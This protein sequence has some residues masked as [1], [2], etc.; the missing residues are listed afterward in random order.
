MSEPTRPLNPGAEQAATASPLAIGT[1]L[2]EDYRVTALLSDTPAMRVYRVALL[3]PLH[4]CPKCGAT[5]QED[6]QFCEECGAQVEQQTALLQETPAADP[7]GAALLADLHIDAPQDAAALPTV[8]EVFVGEDYRY[9]VLPDTSNTLMRFDALLSEAGTALDETDAMLIGATMAR[10][11]ALLHRNGLALGRLTLA[12]LALTANRDVVL[13]DGSAIRRS[14]GQ[15]DQ[16]DDVTQLALVLEKLAGISRQTRRLDQDDQPL[17][18]EN[19]LAT[20]ISDVRNGSLQDPAVLA[21]ALETMLQQQATPM[22]LR[23]RTGFATDP[24]MVRDH[25]EDSLLAWDLR[26][27]WDN[28][29]TNI[30]LYVVADGMGGHEGGEVASGLSI[31]TVAQVLVPFLLD[32]RLQA[33]PLD[34]HELSQRVQQAVLQ[35]NAAIYEASVQRGNDMG[36]TL[37]MAVC[38]W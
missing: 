4:D 18:L 25:N 10:A 37:T 15:A 23:T 35:S 16:I 31:N 12:D 33:G 38:G 3:Q 22:P 30:G 20:I 24:G 13:A 28:I 5:L 36:T 9:A 32:S 8:H 2:K 11:L 7:S 29:L 1:V 27:V 6:D 17:P 21:Q 19:S 14:H 34:Q 26:L